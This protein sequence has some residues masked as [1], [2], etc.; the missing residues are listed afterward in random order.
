MRRGLRSLLTS[1]ADIEVVGEAED[2]A[3]ALE[4][5]AALRP[6]VILLDVR[7][8]GP[9]GVH[10]AWRLRE[11]VPEAKIIILSAYDLKEYVLGALRAGA[12]AY[13]LKSASDETVVDSV[14]RVHRGE[15]LLSPALMDGV[16][17]DF[18]LM[19]R[20]QARG[21][22]NLSEPELAVLDL[23]AKGATMKEISEELHWSERTLKRRVQDIKD[24][25]RVRSRA[26]AVAA[27]I[28]QGLI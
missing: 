6:E 14:R 25:L 3:T 11:C 17:S 28:R 9:D 27:A 22:A 26:Q 20:A 12:H 19:A 1:C 21:E 2:G 23:I 15:R 18:H 7:L 16:L 10:V 8:P 5:A 13:L 4:A 24:K